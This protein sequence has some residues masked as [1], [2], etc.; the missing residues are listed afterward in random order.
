MLAGL[1]RHT[2]V[3]KSNKKINAVIELVRYRSHGNLNTAQLNTSEGI[4]TELCKGCKP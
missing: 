4:K 3:S 1:D 2:V